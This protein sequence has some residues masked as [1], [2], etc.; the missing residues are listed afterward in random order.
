M[1]VL[2]AARE[3]EQSVITDFVSPQSKNGDKPKSLVD[4]VLAMDPS[5]GRGAGMATPAE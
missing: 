3:G 1:I 2:T 5:I 4:R